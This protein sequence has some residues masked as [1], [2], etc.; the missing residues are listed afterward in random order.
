MEQIRQRLVL[1]MLST[2]LKAFSQVVALPLAHPSQSARS[3]LQPAA[4]QK[5]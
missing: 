4:P 3:L 5:A 2:F 1:L